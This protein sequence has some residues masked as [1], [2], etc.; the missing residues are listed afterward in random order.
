MQTLNNSNGR[1]SV[2]FKISKVK[3][4]FLLCILLE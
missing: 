1:K 4:R 2:D 3:S